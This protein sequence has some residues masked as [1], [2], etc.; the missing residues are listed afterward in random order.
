MLQSLIYVSR[1]LLVLPV[2]CGEIKAI[3][4]VSERRNAALGVRG[5]LLFTER[6]FAQLLEG[7]PSAVDA[8]MRSIEKDHRHEAVTVIETKPIDSYRFADWSLSYWGDAGYVDTQIG[9]LLDGEA[10]EEAADLYMLI[11]RMAQES[12]KAGG[13]I[14]RPSQRC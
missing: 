10:G 13:P 5:S 2:Q 14:G 6:H 9:R 8:V 12:R 3:V 7:P 4:A 1:S 11:Q